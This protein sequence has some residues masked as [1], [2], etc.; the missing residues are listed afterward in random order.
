MKHIL[1]TGAN[2]YIGTSFINYINKW[3][4]LYEIDVIDMHDSSWK[5]R[6]FERY[7]T[8]YHVAGIAHIKET[9]ENAHLYY[10]INSELVIETA[11][12]AK[13]DGVT[14]FIYLS[15]MSVYGLDAGIITK[16]TVPNPKSN[17]GKSKMLAEEGLKKLDDENFKIAII[18]APMVYGKDCNGNFQTIVKLVNKFNIFPLCKNRRSMIYIENLC[19]F[20]KLLID[21]NL[22]GLFFPQ[23]K[24]YIETSKMA[25]LIAKAMGKNIHMSIFAGIMVVFMRPFVSMA[26]KAF[27]S[28]IYKDTEDFNYS[29]CIVNFYDSIFKSI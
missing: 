12:K 25:G 22:S 21:K 9:K 17:Y 3:S 13:A 5:E 26:N 27:G 23:N 28:L 19:A 11:K 10:E 1:I 14:Q 18:R 16:D 2:S 8:I 29:Y 7:N 6:N 4:N 24:E 20:V 15:S